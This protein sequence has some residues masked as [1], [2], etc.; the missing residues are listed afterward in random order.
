M[1]K[2]L[3]VDDVQEI[4]E[5]VVMILESELDQYEF[6]EFSSGNQAISYL[7]E[8]P[9]DVDLII[10]DHNMPDGTGSDVYTF[11]KDNDLQI[12][13]IH[14]S[15]GL[16]T[17]FEKLKSL[18]EDHP[19]NACMTKP[20]D[21][22]I[23][24]SLTMSALSLKKDP[25]EKKYTQLSIVNVSP[26]IGEFF[27]VYIEIDNKPRLLF[28]DSTTT[29]QV[30]IIEL[31]N[32]GLTHVL[33][34]TDEY[35]QWIK[36]KLS[37]LNKMV[38]ECH[39]EEPHTIKQLTDTLFKHSLLII[40]Q[41]NPKELNLEKMTKSFEIVLNTLWDKSEIKKDLLKVFSHLGYLSGHSAICM[42]LSWLYT[43][44]HKQGDLSLFHKL[45]YASLLHDISLPD[46]QTSALLTR[47][48][49]DKSE[50]K[51]SEKDFILQHPNYSAEKLESL[52][53]IDSDTLRIIK[54]HHE[55][56]DGSGYPKSLSKSNS[57][58]L[59]TAFQ[60]ILTLAH[61]IY[62]KKDLDEIRNDDRLKGF[63]LKDYQELLDCL[64][65]N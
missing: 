55:K 1:K 48:D 34:E 7:K 23:L 41:A 39:F 16:H 21:D 9:Q 50:Y 61:I 8:S 52:D 17:E 44:K 37:H 65:R 62:T 30:K 4:T 46:D 20:F 19:A 56:P 58:K 60:F 35:H 38:G 2:I 3:V 45:S 64:Q 18:L 36:S 43:K 59:S 42:V 33:V 26:Y 47:S 31:K 10:C 51:E 54:E 27:K 6:L 5:L 49:V 57:H 24:T 11:I 53:V 63:E 25:S 12:P 29:D 15:T 22:E 40:N 28:N 32:K 14:M 13:Y